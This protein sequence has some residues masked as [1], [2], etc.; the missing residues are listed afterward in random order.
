MHRVIT[1]RTDKLNLDE[2]DRLAALHAYAIL[3]TPAEHVFDAVVQLAATLC[4]TPM[5]FLSFVA[6]ERQWFKAALGLGDLRQTPRELAFCDHTIRSRALLEVQDARVD[7][8]FRNHPL[9]VSAPKL[10]FYAGMPLTTASGYRI[11]TVCV[12]DLESRKLSHVQRSALEHLAEIIMRLLESRKSERRATRLGEILDRSQSEIYV[13]SAATLRCEYAS[14]GAQHNT[15][16]TLAELRELTPMELQPPRKAAEFND[17]ITVLLNGE[18]TYVDIESKFVRKNFSAYPVE[19]RLQLWREDGHP[20]LVAVASDI[21]KRKRY[22]QRLRTQERAMEGAMDGMAILDAESRYVYMNGAHAR[23][24]GYDDPRELIGQSW[25]A[26]YEPD[27]IA[28]IEHDV[29]PL[30]M[31]DGRWTGEAAGK[32]RDGSTFS[33]GLSLTLLPAG[34]LVCVCRD[35][36]AQK[37]AEEKLHQEKELA[38]VTLRSIGDAVITTDVQGLITSLNPIAENMTGWSGAQALGQPIESVFRVIDAATREPTRDPVRVALAQNCIVGLAADAMLINRH[39]AQAAVEDSAA[40]IHDRAGRVIGAVLIF[41]DVTETRSMA[42]R[43]A[44]LAQHDPLTELPNRVLLRDRMQHAAALSHRHQHSY[45]LLLIDL[46][47]F[48]HVNDSLGHEA[49]DVLLIEVAQRLRACVRESDT[50]CRQGGDEFIILLPEIDHANDAAQ[51]ASKVLDACTRPFTVYDQDLHVG[52]SIG[53]AVFP[54][55]SEDVDAVMRNADAAMYYAKQQG[56]NN[57]QFYTPGM[58]ARARER[59]TLTNELRRALANDEFVLH[60]QPRIDLETLQVVGGE[61]LIRWQHPLRGLV[62]PGEFIPHIEENGLIVPVGQWVMRAAC[63]QIR[64]WLDASIKAVPISVNVSGAQFRSPDFFNDI[65]QLLA[66]YRIEPRL[67]EIELTEST[68]MHDTQAISRL[69]HQLKDMGL[70]IAIDDFG[71]GFSSLSQLRRFPI[72]TLKID[73]SF[74]QDLTTDPDDAAIT[75]A[76][77][78]MAKSLRQEVVAEGVELPEQLSFLRGLGCDA[79]QGYLFYRPLEATAFAESLAAPLRDQPLV[80]ESPPVIIS[81][82]SIG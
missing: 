13:F 74:V 20:L 11:G 4:G 5:A 58:T 61:A 28:R 27:E 63:R 48:K 62:S 56:R 3:D 55:D 57:Y 64:L 53:I 14:A 32:R 51:V 16:Y 82:G 9:V 7:V 33:E 60:Y 54:G 37:L 45:A 78:S 18:Q 65:F 23:L 43:M 52:A 31:R 59:L 68:V 44:H 73:R 50:V 8:R 36:S 21:S 75:A 22:E 34:D 72:D 70:R 15:G 1:G 12:A 77:V 40:P 47:Q 42:L 46:D 24:F 79:A 19:I 71:T 81:R 10:R 30:L 6:E 38:L 29:F 69:L 66:E 39:G 67:I 80:H 17:A 26:F 49:G 41:R 2:I 76:I 25:T 35:I